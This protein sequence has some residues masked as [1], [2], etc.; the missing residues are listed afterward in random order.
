M[1]SAP[2]SVLLPRDLVRAHDPS[3]LADQAYLAGPPRLPD[4][5]GARAVDVAT[6]AAEA[7]AAEDRLVWIFTLLLVVVSAGYTAVAIAGTLMMSTSGRARTSPS[8][9][10]RARRT[11]RCWARSRRS[12]CSWSC[13][14]RRSAW[15]SPCP[16]C[17]ACAPGWPR[18]WA[19]R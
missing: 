7:D 1:G 2:V 4:G 3:S 15:W 10:C 14:G 16:R 12:R 5:L 19:P 8:C 11:G 13:S 18:R 17:S 9:G 6:Y